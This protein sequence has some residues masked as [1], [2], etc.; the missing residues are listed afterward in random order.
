[1]NVNEIFNHAMNSLT[2][3]TKTANALAK[4]NLTLVDGAVAVALGALVTAVIAAL[5]TLF[6]VSWMS[7]FFAT[8]P[9]MGWTAPVGAGVGIIAAI[10][11]LIAVPIAMVIV[12]LILSFIV[13]IVASLL[14]G[15]GDFVKFASTWAF[16]MAAV[17]ALAWIPLINWLAGLY[18]LYLLYVFLQ[19]TMKMNSNQ[20]ALTVIALF[21]IGLVVGSVFTIT[22]STTVP[23]R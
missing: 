6:V 16:P 15:R 11:V 19:P 14:G 20:A 12:W 9:M 21:V 10:A 18:A 13:W 22:G 4:K 3:P 7:M 17:F 5:A 8:M 2:Q 1:M 23:A